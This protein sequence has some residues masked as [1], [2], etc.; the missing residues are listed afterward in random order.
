MLSRSLVRK[1]LVYDGLDWIQPRSIRQL[2]YIM[3][4]SGRLPTPDR[5]KKNSDILGG[6]QSKANMSWVHHDHQ[7]SRTTEIV[8]FD[9]KPIPT[10]KLRPYSHD[11]EPESSNRQ[12]AKREK[13]SSKRLLEHR[14]WTSPSGHDVVKLHEELT[15]SEH[16]R[17][18]TD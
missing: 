7:K 5:L 8:Q 6:S 10:S 16:V 9:G 18:K 4:F 14:S 2:L 1:L 15:P 17:K 11:R 12:L 3:L 13:P